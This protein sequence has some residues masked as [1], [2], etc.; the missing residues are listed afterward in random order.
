MRCSTAASEGLG[1]DRVLLEL[2]HRLPQPGAFGL[3]G[4]VVA[5]Q[6]VLAAAQRAHDPVQRPLRG[7]VL[8]DVVAEPVAAGQPGQELPR[9]LARRLARV[10]VL[11]GPPQFDERAGDPRLGV[12]PP[13]ASARL[14]TVRSSIR[15][16]CCGGAADLARRRAR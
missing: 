3:Q 13:P 16:D 9:P 6:F 2:A 4:G 1:E 15:L 5:A 10:Q 14:R 11:H 8:G 12:L 7:G